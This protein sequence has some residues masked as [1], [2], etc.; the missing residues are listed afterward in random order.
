MSWT[1]RLVALLWLLPAAVVAD[2]VDSVLVDKSDEK[3][4]LLSDGEV[5]AEYS[6]AL[7]ASPDGHKQ[8]QGDERTP[9]GEYVLDYKL[10]DSSYYKAIH[11]SYPNEADRAA[12]A[13]RGVDPGG[14]IMIHG[15]RNG[16]GWLSLIAQRFD[17]TDGC[18]AVTNREMDEIWDLV[19]VPTPI[20]IRE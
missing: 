3:L 7:G 19:S 14:A 20:E 5:I 9:E 1:R 13:E 17:W 2:S 10:A 12:A 11:I 18:I 15:Q 6:V 8:E 4:Y 16:F